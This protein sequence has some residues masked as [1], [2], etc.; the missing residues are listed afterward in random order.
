[1]PA[2]LTAEQDKPVFAISDG[3]PFKRNGGVIELKE[4]NDRFAFSIDDTLA[5]VRRAGLNS[6]LPGLGR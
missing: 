2:T 4:N 1:M 5:D 3:G 6:C